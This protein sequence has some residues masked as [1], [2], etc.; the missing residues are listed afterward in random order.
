MLGVINFEEF[1]KLN[2]RYPMILYPCFRLQDRIQKA[3]LGEAHWTEIHQ[4]YC[5]FLSGEKYKVHTLLIIQDHLYHDDD[6]DDDHPYHYRH[7]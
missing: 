1:Q 2:I 7:M 5:T 4:R 3:T 6:D